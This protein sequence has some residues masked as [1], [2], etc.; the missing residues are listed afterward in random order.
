MFVEQ[1]WLEKRTFLPFS[2]Y[3]DRLD[4]LL[5]AESRQQGQIPMSFL[6]L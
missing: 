5:G 2:R 6:S 3:G 4:S 1:T